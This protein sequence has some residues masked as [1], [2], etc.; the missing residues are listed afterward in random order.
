MNVKLWKKRE[1]LAEIIFAI[2]LIIA[3][4][5]TFLCDIVT[6]GKMVFFVLM[7]LLEASLLVLIFS[8]I[9]SLVE[10]YINKYKIN[11]ERIVSLAI[12]FIMFATFGYYFNLIYLI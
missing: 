10:L 7:G 1:T 4:S 11:F 5:F 3:V 8:S 6:N 2:C 9:V 12:Y